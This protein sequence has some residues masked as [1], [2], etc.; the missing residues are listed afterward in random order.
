MRFQLRP[1]TALL[2]LA[3]A[4][5]AAQATNGMNLEG[6]GPIATAM[7][8][9]AMAYN[10]GTAA[11]MN[12]PATLTMVPDGTCVNLAA[13]VLGPSVST[14]SKDSSATSFV[15][16]AFGVTHKQNNLVTGFAVFGQGG[17]GTTYSDS[18]FY[19]GLHSAM[20]ANV[21]D[22][23][24]RNR[25]ELGVG[26]ALIP[27]A[28]QAS[29]K[30]SFGATFDYAW[31][32]LDLKML[33]DGRHFMDYA[34]GLGG[35]GTYG[36]ASGS[37]INSLAGM[38]GGA[39]GQISDINWGYFDF[40]DA[41]RYSGRAKGA[42]WGGKIGGTYQLNSQL[43]LGASYHLK[44]RF[45]DLKT[46]TASMTMNVAINGFGNVSMPVE[47]K[48]RV[49]NFS[50]PSQLGL[51]LAYKPNDQ[52]LFATDYRLIGWKDSM[53]SFNMSFEATSGAFAG[54]NMDLSMK[55]N[56][57]DQHVFMIG[58]SY[59]YNGQL[60]LRAGLNLANNPVPNDTVNPLFPAIVR[61]HVTGGFGYML[62]KSHSVD[63]SMTYAPEVKVASSYGNIS[64]SQ[65][66]GQLMYS[67]R[68]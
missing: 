26:R 13:G 12:N 11:V 32:S 37:M 64:H 23:G 28:W 45:S 14:N 4:P 29:E 67:W 66:N 40:S 17:M 1:A 25:S 52:W 15:M 3:F 36:T 21:T 31:T 53:K 34:T 57:K 50:W 49:T 51:G 61:N 18:S 47:G 19:G 65:I 62:D 7:G 60:T 44:T 10:N 43:T 24:Q 63:F 38:M 30:L 42:G 58:G 22:P 41:T 2:A 68:F 39:P 48:L 46:D 55:Q 33:M 6:Y 35:S 59:R 20:G 5:L 27:L 16:P 54:Q 9:A 8:G 56:W